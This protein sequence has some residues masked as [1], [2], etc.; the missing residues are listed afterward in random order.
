M[1]NI[2][3]GGCSIL[4]LA[5]PGTALAQSAASSELEGDA[6][7]VS[8]SVTRDVEGILLPNTPRAKQV[9]TQEQLERNGPGQTVLDSIN[10]IPGVTFTNN[11][12]YGSGGGQL[13][14]RGFSADRISLTFDGL[15]LN[16]TGNYAIYSNQQLDPEIIDNVNVNLGS[17]DID[18]PT[19]AASG[20]TVNYQSRTPSEDMG[21]LF[22]VSA[23]DFDMFRIFGMFDT[24]ALTS[25]GLRAFISASKQDYNNPINNYG[26]VDKT[27]FNGKLYQPLAGDD[28]VWIAA[29]YNE[30]RNNFFGS[31]PLR[32]DTTNGRIVGPGSA[33]RFPLNRDEATYDIS[34]PCAVNLTARPG[35]VDSPNVCGTEFD[36]RYNPSKT[37]NVRAVGRFTLTDQ[38]VLTVEPSF[39]WTRANGG[40]T[41]SANEGIGAL[42][43]TG[44]IGGSFFFG[45]DLNGDGDILD[46]VTVIQPSQT[47]TNRYGVIS[48]LIYDITPDHTVRLAYTLDYGDHRQT[49]EAGMVY[50]NGE[51]MSTMP[52]YDNPL[53]DRDGNVLQKRDR[54]SKAILHQF[55]GEYRGSFAEGRFN[56]VAGLRAPFFKRD[57]QNN[58]FTT[59]DSGFVNCYATEAANAAYAAA[60]PTVQGPQTRKLDYNKVLPSAGFTF[61]LTDPMQVFFNYSKGLQVPGTDALYNSFFFA[62]DAGPANPAPET[63]DN[64]DLGVRYTTGMV[65][66]MAVGWYTKYANR[67]ASAYDPETD[68][69]VYR[70]LGDVEKYG[71]DGSINVTP[72]PELFIGLFGSYLK[73]EI[74]DDVQS[75]TNAA[76]NPIFI[77]TAGKRE[78]G[79]PTY[80]YGAQARA[81]LGPVDLGATAKRTG[82]RYIYDTN[83]PV[84]A[85]TAGA[86]VEVFG[87]ST[88]AYWLVN[89]DARINMEWAGLNDRTFVQLNVYNLFDELYAGT[90]TAGLNQ[91]NVLGNGVVTGTPG[92]VPNVQIGAP[93][94]FSVSLTAAF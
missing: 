32:T 59:S 86:P 10:I 48:N 83:L 22:S 75:G 50:G 44:N 46:R 60:N 69:N 53:T 58:C 89:L 82:G 15:P 33:N 18:S 78:S 20:S 66:A 81:S 38:L 52:A 21:A 8:G 85:G 93:R 27:Q 54:E 30:N 17:T 62:P 80:S 92:S 73:S 91:G 36:R 84:F 79:A 26:V 40:G 28:Y 12:A 68:R 65:Q 29:H 11:D 55:S 5:I 70:N 24:G 45:R 16:D 1:K 87:A 67:L 63:T 72:I 57:L 25:S 94:T 47:R 13:S 4:A 37:G 71:I 61:D 34:A 90:Y 19:A 43:L 31:V 56:V 14:I 39:Q 42:G 74:K 88:P 51:P 64:F 35:Q 76:G 41:T 23:G 49:G 3:F 77:A 7:I 2:L 6:I 9:L